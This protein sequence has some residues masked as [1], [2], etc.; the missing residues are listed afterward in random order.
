MPVD[1]ASINSRALAVLPSLLARWLPNGRRAGAEYLVGSLQG[2][3]GS[4]LSINLNT[5][6]WCDFASDNARGGDPI[7]LYAALNRLSQV[8]AAERLAIELGDSP[9]SA[10]PSQR[11]KTNGHRDPPPR[12]AAE[13]KRAAPAIISPVP[14]DAPS[15]SFAHTTHG[16][17]SA[18]W[19]YR[20]EH[21]ATL[22]HVARFDT[23][24]SSDG[25]PTGKQ[26]LPLC[27]TASGWRWTGYPKP[28]PLY[29]LDR[30]AA[31]PDAPVLVVEGERCASVRVQG[32]VVVTWPGGTAGV[33]HADWRPLAS[34]NITI[35]P[36]ADEPG[37]KAAMAINR[38]LG[39]RARVPIPPAGV[40]QGWDIADA[41]EDQVRE[42]LHPPISAAEAAPITAAEDAPAYDEPDP[43]AQP[44][45]CLGH[46]R[47]VYFYLPK[48]GGR[49]IELRS[50][51]HKQQQLLSL[52]PLNYWEQA[53][54][55]NWLMATNSL[56]RQCEAAG[57]YDS[58]R[59]R[60]RG[61]W[62][63]DG[64]CVVHLGDRLIVDGASMP[65]EAIKSRFIYETGAPLR[66][67]DA[68][69]LRSSEAVK[70]HDL[71]KMLN[72]ERPMSATMLA[73]W[74]V[75]APICGA[76]AWRPHIQIQ[77]AKDSGKS[78]IYENILSKAIGEIGLP[79]A[80][81]V[82][83][84]GI[85]WSLGSDARPVIVDEI[86][87]K[88]KRGVERVQSIL[89]LF[90]YAST[91]TS[92]VIVKGAQGGGVNTFRVR[93]M[94]AFCA[95]TVAAREA[96]DLSRL[97]VC[98]VLRDTSIQREARFDV[99]KAAQQ[100]TLTQAFIDGLH[101][102]TLQLIPVIRHNAEVF[103]RAGAA[104]LGTRRFGDQIGALLAGAYSLHSPQR[105][106]SDTAT[107]W[108]NNQDWTEERAAQADDD[109]EQ[110][111]ARLM[112]FIVPVGAP[113]GRTDRSIG[114]LIL[115]A[116]RNKSDDAIG[117]DLAAETLA[118]HGF[119][120]QPKPYGQPKDQATELL[121]ANNHTS[122]AEALRDSPW[123]SAWGRHL[124]T[125]PGATA[126]TTGVKFLGHLTRVTSI[127]LATLLN[128]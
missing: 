88:D 34:R 86:E 63:D 72:W 83:E 20:D 104:A 82:T 125:L 62:W 101:A 87:A 64:R 42:M 112:Q 44:F 105:V 97:T 39:G 32:F 128:P 59:L 19:T 109:A 43:T 28:R 10:A 75:I 93:S 45:R 91:E 14:A 84:P 127:P 49:V 33:G 65:P 46:D 22:F 113:R 120:I 5:S 66:F 21:G 122:I 57:I 95:I 52:A 81:S 54:N 71:C 73:G 111:L 9:T 13:P 18:H 4:S 118:R 123:S 48:R 74:M 31:S 1:F 119:R 117:S 12:T 79:L 107:A 23:P 2:E 56:M 92:A 29:G 102:R 126:I 98:T 47:G 80:S 103:S 55:V 114:E 25:Q 100:D 35:W 115:L 53:Y 85:R 90:R 50:A 30:L 58:W 6:R 11:P 76:L 99:L 40:P 60:G 124:K 68:A 41:T 17:A 121:I 96:A 61:A 70:L 78:W 94:A 27:Y 26:I 110:C 38:L 3:P 8:V 37:L 15:P 116:S 36:D 7:S 16:I 77:G 106:T 108:V 69:P 24:A 51:A 89:D 67:G